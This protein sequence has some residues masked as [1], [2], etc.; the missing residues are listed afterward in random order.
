MGYR[1]QAEGTLVD[2]LERMF[3]GRSRRDLR[4][5]IHDGRVM[6]NGARIEDHRASVKAGDLIDCT[7][8]GKAVPIH[9]DVRVLYEDEHIFIVEKKA[10][11]LTSG[12]VRGRGATVVDVLEA[13][14]R[15]RG[16]RRVVY[17][18][19]RLDRGVSGLLLLAKSARL[20]A[21]V[22]EDS[23]GFLEERV[24]H[25]VVEGN[26]RPGEGTIRGYLKDDDI[27]KIVRPST[28]VEGGKL[29]VTRYRVLESSGRHSLLEARLETGRKNQI[30]AHL[31]S[32][33]HPVAGD[34]KYGAKT[35]PFGRI[36]LHAARLTIRH[37]ASGRTMTFESPPGAMAHLPRGGEERMDRRGPRRWE[38]GTPRGVIKGPDPAQSTP[39]RRGRD[40][41]PR[42]ASPRPRGGSSS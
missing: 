39:R 26:P 19:H 21:V 2:A 34:S 22:R 23:R 27:D 5:L 31:A 15:R 4:R 9:P 1:V 17:P 20:A 16:Q 14:L 28:Q 18:C 40:R 12:G 8:F 30:R 6:R 37:P 32:I 29:S 41:S 24:Y 11:I 33:G 10:G 7:S 42:R 36:A 25:A 3:Q 35:D 13:N 38:P